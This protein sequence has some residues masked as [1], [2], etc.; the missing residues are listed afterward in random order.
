MGTA[1][2]ILRPETLRA[3]EPDPILTVS[4][5]ADTHRMLSPRSS[6]EHGPWQTSRTPYLRAIMDALSPTHPAETVV[7]VKSA[8]VGGTECGLNWVGYV[9]HRSPGPMLFVSPTVEL[10]KRTSRQRLEPLIDESPALSGLIATP[11]E[12]DSHN[13]I[14]SKEFPGGII[15][16]TGANSAV[17]L[18]SM[19]ARF[20]F[21]DEVD[22]YPA[23]ADD[24]GDPVSLA[25][26]RAQT[27]QRRKTL[28]V[29]TPTIAG[30]SRIEAEFD[31]CDQQFDYHVPCPHCGL[32]Q[33]LVFERLRWEAGEPDRVQY[34]CAGCRKA[35][36]EHAK[37]RMLAEGEWIARRPG[38][39][40]SLGFRISGLYSP[41]GWLSWAQIAK[42]HEQAQGRSELLRV[43]TN[44]RL[45]QSYAESAEQPDWRRLYDRRETYE[46]WTVP[47][48]GLFLV[49]GVDVQL[50]RVE[51]ELVAYGR[52]L[53]SWSVGYLVVPGEIAREETRQQL[54]AFLAREFSTAWGASMRIMC[55]CI[56]AGYS[57]THVYKWARQHK[58]PF[59]GPA[60]SI[61]RGPHVV[62][63]I[64]GDDKW[65][66]IIASAST[67]EQGNKKRGVRVFSVAKYQ[68]WRELYDFLRLDPPTD[69]EWAAGTRFPPGYCHFPEYHEDYFKQLC[70]PRFV[71]EHDTKGVAKAKWVKDPSIPA[72]VPDA[73]AYA[74]AAAA[75]CGMDRFREKDWLALERAVGMV[76]KPEPP[77]QPPPPRADV[78]STP[79][80]P[81]PPPRRGV[82]RSRYMGRYR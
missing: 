37:T 9:I 3:I 34:E 52:G 51:V 29:S 24:E 45:G 30:L 81:A 75:L 59:Y 47:T 39:G 2:E 67:S 15:V 66:Q 26:V 12:R 38:R 77:P 46:Q 78:F 80:P 63:A 27:F 10:S 36:P 68:A 14:F 20:L 74:R 32:R 55:L 60:G 50:N 18:R 76:A 56:D 17:G 44:T 28:M 64:K 62:A 61:A 41:F 70:G 33:V 19:P 8:Q 40:R 35:I 21:F 57:S 16:L 65:G 82:I 73:R 11:R 53:E 48:G 71:I 7:F 6:A 49:A 54:T 13:T 23:S 22:A 79:P 42:E 58:Q 5:W 31:R 72:E 1:A 4:E 25:R 43:F 69:A